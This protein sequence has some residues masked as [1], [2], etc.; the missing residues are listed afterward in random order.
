[1][2]IYICCDLWSH[3]LFPNYITQN[4]ILRSPELFYFGS[5]DTGVAKPDCSDLSYFCIK[6]MPKKKK[7]LLQAG[8]KEASEWKNSGVM[9]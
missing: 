3:L 6:K 9:N 7:K 1:M 4:Y 2:T 5:H 8:Y